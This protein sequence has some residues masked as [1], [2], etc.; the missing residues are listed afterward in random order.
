MCA[1]RTKEDSPDK[2]KL[3]EGPSRIGGMSGGE[4]GTED[5]VRAGRLPVLFDELI[6]D[7]TESLDWSRLTVEFYHSHDELLLIVPVKGPPPS[8]VE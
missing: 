1:A 7:N 4:P 5:V 8:K 6:K 3:E 2:M